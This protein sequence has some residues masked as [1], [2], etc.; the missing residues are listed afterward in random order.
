VGFHA[1][2]EWQLS[3]SEVVTMCV[4]LLPVAV[5]PLWQEE[6]FPMTCV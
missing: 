1:D 2:A 4:A 6:Q 5:V 3:H